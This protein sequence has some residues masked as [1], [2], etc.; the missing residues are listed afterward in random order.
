MEAT[1]VR[2]TLDK[3]TAEGMDPLVEREQSIAIEL[4]M[5]WFREAADTAARS[6]IDRGDTPFNWW[7]SGDVWDAGFPPVYGL[8]VFRDAPGDYS[9]GSILLVGVKGTV[10][11]VIR[12]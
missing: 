3:R 7:V 10:V 6:I 11:R 1:D 5:P 8:P 9:G 2:L 12:P 4:A